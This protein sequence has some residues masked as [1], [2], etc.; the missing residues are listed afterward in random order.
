M[1]DTPTKDT[2]AKGDQAT[3]E[4]R[5]ARDIFEAVYELSGD[6]RLRALRSACGQ[7]AALL[8]RVEELLRANADAGGFLGTPTWPAGVETA[9]ASTVVI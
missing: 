6:E 9:T 4:S 1:D 3:P 8:S 2:A 5:R 7:D